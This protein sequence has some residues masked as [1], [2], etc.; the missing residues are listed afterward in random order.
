MLLY[1]VTVKPDAEIAAEWLQWMQETHIPELL[2]TG[3]FTEARLCRL[4][5]EEPDGPTFAIQYLCAGRADY[6]TYLADWAPVMRER[7]TVRFG[8]RFVAFRTVLDVL[9]VQQAARF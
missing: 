6:E 8:G 1:N 4:E 9:E 2:Q 7:S 5:D 3:L